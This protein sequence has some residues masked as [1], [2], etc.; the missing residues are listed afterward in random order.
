M[1]MADRDGLIWLDGEMVP[2]REAKTHVLTHTLHYGLGCFEGVR[3]YNTANGP[4]IFRL[5]EHTDRLFRSAHI[6]NMKMPFSKDE[7]KASIKEF[8][9]ASL[10]AAL[11]AVDEY[12]PGRLDDEQ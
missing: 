5:K 2:W 8:Y 1:S 12:E 6:L 7:I 3:A 10:E 9:E 4:A 11:A